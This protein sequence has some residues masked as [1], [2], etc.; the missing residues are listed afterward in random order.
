M[1]KY[2]VILACLSLTACAGLS[3]GSNGRDGINGTN[4]VNGAPGKSAYQIWLDQGNTGT[5]QDFLDSLV[6]TNNTNNQTNTTTHYVNM[7]EYFENIVRNWYNNVYDIIETTQNWPAH[8]GYKHYEYKSYN[9]TAA[10]ASINKVIYD[11]KE[12]QLANY[13]VRNSLTQN[14]FENTFNDHS[15]SSAGGYV[16]NREGVGANLYT[17]T[18]NSVF[19][20]G[21][22]AYLEGSQQSDVFIKGNA[23]FTYKP[24]NPELVLAYDNYYTFHIVKDGL[25]GE[26]TTVSGTNNTGNS[27]FNVTTGA[28]TDTYGYDAKFTPYYVQK[29][30]IQETVGTY[31]LDFGSGDIGGNTT[32]DFYLHG[33]FGGTKQ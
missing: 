26:T 21:T 13:G 19:T 10:N 20:G 17:P 7:S 4:G 33:A 29:G 2:I 24:T 11:E 6:A 5:E 14:E 27:F 25:G 9:D 18:T 32:N 28:Y 3:G 30:A 22:L 15:N 8:N 31:S 1:K 23:T 16:H 12:M